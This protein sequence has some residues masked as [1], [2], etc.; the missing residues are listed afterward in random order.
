M[1]TSNELE[2]GPNSSG[3]HCAPD[4][5]HGLSTPMESLQLHARARRVGRGGFAGGWR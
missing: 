1:S 5:V 2:P 3:E 4:M